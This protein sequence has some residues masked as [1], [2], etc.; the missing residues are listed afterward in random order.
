MEP[1]QTS[2]GTILHL[3]ADDAEVQRAAARE[4]SRAELNRVVAQQKAEIRRKHKYG[5]QQPGERLLVP[6]YSPEEPKIVGKSGRWWVKLSEVKPIH[7]EAVTTA[8][9]L[10]VQRECEEGTSTILPGN[11]A[12]RYMSLLGL[13]GCFIKWRS[14]RASRV[15]INR[16]LSVYVALLV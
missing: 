14:T 9:I 15:Y 13:E 6:G 16:R 8:G 3:G 5:T 7:T 12:A 2:S 1:G 4:R 11:V 10:A